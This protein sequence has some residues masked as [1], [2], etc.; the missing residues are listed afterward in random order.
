[1]KSFRNKRTSEE[2]T[3]RFVESNG[4]DTDLLK[5]MRLIQTKIPTLGDH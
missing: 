3:H 5:V 2:Y 1:M 4:T